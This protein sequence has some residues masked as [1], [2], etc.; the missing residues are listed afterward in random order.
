MTELILDIETTGIDPTENRIVC[1][2]VKDTARDRIYSFQEE[3]ESSLLTKFFLFVNRRNVERIVAYNTPFDRRF[4]AARAALH[5]VETSGFLEIE[6]EDL[7]SVLTNGGYCY[8]RNDTHSLDEWAEFFLD[9]EKLMEGGSVPEKYEEGKIEEIVE[10]CEQ[11]VEITHQIWEKVNSIIDGRG[12][13]R[14]QYG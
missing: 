7:M 4:I 2:S 14:I 1:I 9:E 11:D 10:Y 12:F 6:Y 8:S 13:R 5:N 3:D